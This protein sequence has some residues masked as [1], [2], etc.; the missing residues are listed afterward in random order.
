MEGADPIVAPDDLPKWWAK[1]LRLVGL[2]WGGTRYA[3]GTGAPRGL[4]PEG[5]ELVVALREIGMALDAS[6]LA[7]QSFCDAVEIGPGNLFASH[8]SAQALVPGDRQLSDAMI[9]AIGERNGIVGLPLYNLFLDKTWS[10]DKRFP[11]TLGDQFRLHAE[12]VAGLIGWDKVAI[13]SDLDGG[14]GL[15][16]TPEEID[17]VADL[18]EIGAVLPREARDGV[19]GGNWLRFLER[20]LPD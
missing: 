7:E 5:R 11:V 6:H 17:T 4:S 8:S 1:G 2:S 18:R 19:L 9:R 16:E 20:V 10:F 12:H 3:G 15:L 13:G 14:F